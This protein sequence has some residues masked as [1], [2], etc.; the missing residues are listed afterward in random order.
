MELYIG[1]YCQGKLD[2]VKE[3][4]KIRE[5]SLVADGR[6]CKLEEVYEKP[7]IN[8]F[9]LFL[10]RM[11][12][13]G[14]EVYEILENIM[15]RNPKVLIICDEVGMG[16]VPFQKEDRVYRETVGR[17]CCYLAEKSETVERIV[18]GIGIKL[19]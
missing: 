7:V 9:H 12:E 8:Q 11:L 3:K 19:C 5:D 6:T 13:D 14:Q 18:C 17:S 16:I 1:G 15:L 4:K 10:K 2:Y